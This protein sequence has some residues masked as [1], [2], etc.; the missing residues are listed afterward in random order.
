MHIQL[1]DR[2]L[3]GLEETCVCT[4]VCHP[5]SP[6]SDEGGSRRGGPIKGRWALGTFLFLE[7]VTDDDAYFLL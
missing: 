3:V 7:T 1:L 2:P 4:L 6:E 5:I